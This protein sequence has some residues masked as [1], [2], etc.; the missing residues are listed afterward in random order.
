M[1]HQNGAGP[2][3]RSDGGEAQSSGWLATATNSRPHTK[4][5]P[6]RADLIG[7]VTAV[8]AATAVRLSPAPS[9]M[10]WCVRSARTA[11]K[12]SSMRHLQ[13]RIFDQCTRRSR[14]AQRVETCCQRQRW[15]AG[16]LNVTARG[17][18]RATRGGLKCQT[19]VTTA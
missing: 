18:F 12:P 14:N 2:A 13:T 17:G 11:S 19:G 1:A 7:A 6:V 10:R 3:H 4:L 8:A 15:S 9:P 16:G 5:Q